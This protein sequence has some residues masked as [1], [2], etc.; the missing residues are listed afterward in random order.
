MPESQ[1]RLVKFL[2]S[3]GVASRRAAGDLVKSGRI[4]VNGKVVLEPGFQVAPSDTVTFDGN[5]VKII[6]QLH[7]IMLNKPRGY[8]CTHS[9]PHA[10]LKAVDLITL[11]PPVRLFSAGRLDKES[12]GLILF[13]NDGDYIEKITHPRNRILKTYIVR[14][15][16]DFTNAELERIRTGIIDDGELLKVISISRLGATRYK[17]LLNEGKKREIRRLTA[18]AGSPTVELR[19]VKIGELELGDLPEGTFREL[20][21]AE[22]AQSLKSYS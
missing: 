13:S 16:R 12:S 4:A 18:I 1:E 5:P 22:V 9:D 10:P 14:V 19:R 6:A 15:T 8:V 2:S 20:S 17:I 7:Y 3:A 21:A 11:T